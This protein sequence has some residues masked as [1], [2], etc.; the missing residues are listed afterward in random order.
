MRLNCAPVRSIAAGG[1]RRF[2]MRVGVPPG[3][4]VGRSVSVTWGLRARRLAGS[5]RLQGAF[6]VT[7]G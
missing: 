5:D 4:A 6:T 3:L 2:E 7:I 1:R